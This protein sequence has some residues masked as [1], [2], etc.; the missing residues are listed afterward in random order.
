MDNLLLYQSALPFGKWICWRERRLGRPCGIWRRR[1]VRIRSQ[2]WGSYS[3]FHAGGIQPVSGNVLLY[4][5]ADREI[6][7]ESLSGIEAIRF[8]GLKN[9]YQPVGVFCPIRPESAD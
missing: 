2:S 4:K 6:F 3:G 8:R 1:G 5:A 9:P 7:Y